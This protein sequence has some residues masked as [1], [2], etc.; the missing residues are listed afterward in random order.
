MRKSARA[1]LFDESFDPLWTPNQ[2]STAFWIDATDASTLTLS[3]NNITQWADKSGNSNN[4]IPLNGTV[5]YQ[6]GKAVFDGNSSLISANDFPLTGLLAVSVFVVYRKNVSA[7]GSFFG[8]GNISIVGQAFGFYDDGSYAGISY[9]GGM[10]SQIAN[11]PLNTPLVLSISKSPASLVVK[12]NGTRFNTTNQSINVALNKLYLGQW[13][14]YTSA[15]LNGTISEMIILSRAAIDS[16]MRLI[17]N[18]LSYK[19]GIPMS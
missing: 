1:V 11:T 2:I 9:A 15:R 18:Y 3:G 5:T 13:V 10:G 14:D 6:D 7:N 12:R 8:W 4:L 17:E 16:E 19:H